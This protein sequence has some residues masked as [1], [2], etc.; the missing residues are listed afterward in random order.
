MAVEDNPVG[1]K[2]LRRALERRGI[3][4]D[5]A[6]NG[7]EALAAAARRHYD[8][9]LMDLEMPEMDGLTAT[10]ELRKLPG[11]HDVPVL[12]LTANTSDQ[13]RE[14][15]RQHGMQAFLGKPIEVNEIWN[16][17]QKHLPAYQ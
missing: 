7:I 12:A 14:R 1:M 11:Y 6:T 5:Y 2:V 17:V 9:V 16:A 10:L 4:A 15:C 3:R 13:I 8:L